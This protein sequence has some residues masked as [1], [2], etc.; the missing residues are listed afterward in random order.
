MSK[1][2]LTVKGFVTSICYK[3]YKC[4]KELLSV[5]YVSQ[6]FEKK[7]V[8]SSSLKVYCAIRSGFPVITDVKPCR[9]SIVLKCWCHHVAPW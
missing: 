9:A 5:K 2:L 4:Y 1:M 8:F 7:M 3:C 6:K